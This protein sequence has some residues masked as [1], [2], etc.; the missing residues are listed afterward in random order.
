[1]PV[2]AN[3]NRPAT[4]RAEAPPLRIARLSHLVATVAFAAMTMIVGHR[5]GGSL[6]GDVVGGAAA[7]LVVA[8]TWR[9]LVLSGGRVSFPGA[10]VAGLAAVLAAVLA[11]ALTG[12]GVAPEAGDPGA[13][14][15]ALFA[16]VVVAPLGVALALA[17][18]ALTR[19]LAARP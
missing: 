5:I 2:P 11:I 14:S 12:R 1:M 19:F 9:R 18:A 3:E 13:V 6:V 16:F 15:T 7:A 17:L 8:G 10:G 4:A